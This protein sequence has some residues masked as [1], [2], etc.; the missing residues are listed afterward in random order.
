MTAQTEKSLTLVTNV[1][2]QNPASESSVETYVVTL[3][4]GEVKFIKQL[5]QFARLHDLGSITKPIY[6]GDWSCQSYADLAYEDVPPADCVK[7]V[8]AEAVA[9]EYDT[10]HVTRT[11][12]HFTARPKGSDHLN[13]MYTPDV[14]LSVLDTDE[15]IVD[16]TEW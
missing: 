13:I 9:V 1:C 6:H 8:M 7:A 16:L 10:I 5:V 3:T 15:A 12:F 2:H 4:A 11:D 14:P